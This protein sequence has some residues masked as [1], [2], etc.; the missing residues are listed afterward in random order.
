MAR[1][2]VYKTG[3]I[4]KIIGVAPRTASNWI[5]TGRLKGRRLPSGKGERRVNR[6]DLQRFMDEYG[7]SEYIKL[8]SHDQ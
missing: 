2:E 3:D 7:I 1:K 4:A 8:E 5:D 6:Q